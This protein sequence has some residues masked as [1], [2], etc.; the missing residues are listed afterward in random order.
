MVTAKRFDGEYAAVA[1]LWELEP[2]DLA[3]RDRRSDQPVQRWIAFEAGTALGAATAWLRPDNRMF[4]TFKAVDDRAIQPLVNAADLDLRRP[5]FTIADRSEPD[6]LDALLESGFSIEVEGERFRIPFSEVTRLVARAW[7]PSEYR[8][9]SVK[10]VLTEAGFSLDNEIRD[11]V[12]GSDGWTG[13]RDWFCEEL[14]SP[15]FEPDAYL[16][17]QVIETG[18]L[19]GLLRIWRN[20]DGPRLGLIGVLPG[21]RRQPVAAA[22]LRQGLA[23]A[24]T[25][26]YDSFVTETSP[27]NA[28]TYPR[29]VRLHS[30]RLG[31]FA[32]L[33]R[34]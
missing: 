32:Q 11:L 23:A 28:N 3:E 10:H 19:V 33:V 4:L 34:R 18:A 13:N 6:R 25:W 26:G 29:M 22:L 16:V 12:P 27:S 5:L 15:E 31:G 17:A 14:Q 7:V 8:I 30:E 9:V 24:S 20:S 2:E 21:H 1:H